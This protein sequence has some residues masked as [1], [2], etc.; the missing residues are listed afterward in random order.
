MTGWKNKTDDYILRRRYSGQE[1]EWHPEGLEYLREALP[2][3]NPG[4]EGIQ[5]EPYSDYQYRFAG[6]CCGEATWSS[7]QCKVPGR[8]MHRGEGGLRIC[9]ARSYDSLVFFNICGLRERVN[10]CCAC[11]VWDY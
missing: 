5:G 9:S 3:S 6:A 10:G 4:T 7:R 8:H 1:S 11:G 2:V